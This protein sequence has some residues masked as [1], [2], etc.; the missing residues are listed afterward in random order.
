MIGMG[1]PA[2]NC[3]TNLYIS[4]TILGHKN[5]NLSSKWADFIELQRYSGLIEM[6][7]ED[8]F[9]ISIVILF[10]PQEYSRVQA[11]LFV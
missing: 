11:L 6:F 1:Q 5:T 4:I 2:H 8:R 7:S 9:A 10:N 3:N